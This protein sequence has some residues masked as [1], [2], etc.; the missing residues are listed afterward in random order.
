MKP[1]VFVLMPFEEGFDGIYDFLIHDPFSNAGY[2]VMRADDILNQRNILEDIIQSI[3]SS[4]LIIADLSTNNPNVYYELGLAH[5]FQKNVMLLAQDIAEVPFDLRSYRVI[6]YSTYFTKMDNARQ[7]IQSYIANLRTGS[8][9]FGSPVTDFG[10][11][12]SPI[13]TKEPRS[14][15]AKSDDRDECGLLDYQVESEEGMATITTV[16]T[17]VGENLNTLTLDVQSAVERIVGPDKGAPRK[18]RKT[19]RSLATKLTDYTSWLQQGNNQYRKALEIVEQSLN[20]MLS[21]EFE[22]ADQDKAKITEFVNILAETEKK[23]QEGRNGFS[24]FVS[25]LDALPK[26]EREF[27]RSNRLMSAEYKIL[28]DNIEQTESMM[29]RARNAA[30]RLIKSDV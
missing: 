29:A 11:S 26:I 5:A 25:T 4:D 20:A 23:I 6:T 27:N 3:I 13:A 21:G 24:E 18:Q 22:I 2:D 15:E 9:R 10:V 8:V 14:S 28:I 1:R 30:T 16:V 17:E 12:A 19:M 7:E